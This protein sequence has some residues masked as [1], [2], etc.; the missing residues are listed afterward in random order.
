[1]PSLNHESPLREIFPRLEDQLA[2]LAKENGLT[3]L[4]IGITIRAT[5]GMIL[6]LATPPDWMFDTPHSGAPRTRL[7]RDGSTDDLRHHRPE[8]RQFLSDEICRC[9][10]V[11]KPGTRTPDGRVAP[12]DDYFAMPPGGLG[13]AGHDRR[14]WSVRCGVAMSGATKWTRGGHRS[15]STR[16]TPAACVRNRACSNVVRLQPVP[17]H[18]STVPQAEQGARM[19]GMERPD[20]DRPRTC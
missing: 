15:S 1:V 6:T 4:D 19:I 12:A 9:H 14:A 3:G 10:N 8:Y 7:P 11:R 2:G 13:S 20:G 5:F 16:C 18:P 17:G